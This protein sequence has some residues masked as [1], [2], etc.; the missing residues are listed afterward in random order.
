M[1]SFNAVL[2]KEVIKKSETRVVDGIS[3]RRFYNPTIDFISESTKN[4]GSF[5]YTGGS[6][7]PVWHCIDQVLVSKNLVDNIID[8]KY[9]KSIK[10]RSL[11]KAV[12]PN[13]EISDH[14]PLFV[15]IN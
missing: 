13:N 7:T 3:Y 8:F 6:S 4:Y 15:E 2:F 12:K 5:Y 14:L 9:L 10:K 1:N 11:L